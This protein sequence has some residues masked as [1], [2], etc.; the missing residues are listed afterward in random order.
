MKDQLLV[1]RQVLGKKSYGAIFLVSGLL[2][3]LLYAV[4]TNLIDVRSGLKYINIA[5]TGVSATFFLLFSILGG[6]LI[7]LQIVAIKNRQKTLT[8]A[9]VGFLGAFLSFFTTTCP[10]CK[11]LLLSWIGFSGSVAILKY[12]TTLAVVSALLLLASIW[13]VTAHLNQ[14][15]Y[16]SIQKHKKS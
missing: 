16:S 3:G 6:L 4:M 5:F 9:K 10:F 11:P 12:G 2:Y 8:S 7:T 15:K 14:G 1:I 13:L